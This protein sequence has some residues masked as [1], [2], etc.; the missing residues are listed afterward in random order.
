MNL[1]PVISQQ[2][3]PEKDPVNPIL[4][5]I[6]KN[7]T[8]RMTVQAFVV[9]IMIYAAWNFYGYYKYVQG[10]SGSYNPYRPPSVEGFLP[11]AALVAFKAMF[12]NWQIDPI[13]PA[14]LVIFL[15]ILVTAWIFR[16]A[17]C[18]WICPLGTLSEYLGKLGKKVM[19]DNIII[20]KWLDFS[21]VALKYVLFFFIVSKFLLLT[22]EQATAFMRMPFYVISDIKVFEF[23]LN[24]GI[25]GAIVIGIFMMLSFLF[26]SFFCRYL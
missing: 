11:I 4:I 8:L 3:D 7:I 19:G 23:F 9:I 10:T 21:L 25:T 6:K 17:L 24:I 20:P 18:S 16:R 13:H 2:K 26:K 12:V 22:G 14:G 5:W 15:A 1:Q